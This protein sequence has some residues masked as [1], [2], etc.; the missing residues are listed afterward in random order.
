VGALTGMVDERALAGRLIRGT[1]GSLGREAVMTQV[2]AAPG[3]GEKQA[4]VAA[5]RAG[6]AAQFSSLTERYRREMLVHCYPM[7]GKLEGA[8]DLVQETFLKAWG[9]RSGFEGRSSLRAWLYRIATNA[10]LDA[11]KRSRRRVRVVDFP[12]TAGGASAA[13]V[14]PSQN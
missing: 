6:G 14:K 4:V 1:G 12:P 8:E 3:A 10:C 13:G 2:D 5:V 9:S 11:I 7:G